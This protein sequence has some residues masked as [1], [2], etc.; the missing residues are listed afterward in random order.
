MLLDG[1]VRSGH[2]SDGQRLTFLFHLVV[3][4]AR[5]SNGRSIPVALAVHNRRKVCHPA[6]ASIPKLPA[7]VTRLPRTKNLCLNAAPGNIQ[8]SYNGCE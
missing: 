8:G 3:R 6:G 1:L 2:F 5:H 4:T 7:H